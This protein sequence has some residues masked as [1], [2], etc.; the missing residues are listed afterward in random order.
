[1]TAS[2][3]E[4]TKPFGSTHGGYRLGSGVKPKKGNFY[5]DN[6]TRLLRDLMDYEDLSPAA[7]EDNLRRIGGAQAEQSIKQLRRLFLIKGPDGDV[8]EQ[9]GR[10]SRLSD[11]RNGHRRVPAWLCEILCA[12]VNELDGRDRQAPGGA[13]EQKMLEKLIAL[14]AI[15]AATGEGDA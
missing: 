4:R 12:W 8:R 1:M 14:A 10:S 11:W 13:R 6:A 5:R 7:F 2:I 9:C 3:R 15:V